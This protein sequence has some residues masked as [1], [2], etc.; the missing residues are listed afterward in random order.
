MT[1]PGALQSLVAIATLVVVVVAVV[2][3]IPMMIVLHAATA[4]LPVTLEELATLIAWTRPM[5]ALVWCERPVAPV[6][7]VMVSDRIPVAA[8]PC[9]ARPWAHRSNRY[10]RR[11]RRADP[12]SDRNLSLGQRCKRASSRSSTSKVGLA[13]SPE[14]PCTGIEI[15]VRGVHLKNTSGDYLGHKIDVRAQLL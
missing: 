6:P 1:G 8:D 3:I 11:W 4:S 7:L 15:K 12:Y 9:I 14:R 13:I 5:G 10:D 2:F